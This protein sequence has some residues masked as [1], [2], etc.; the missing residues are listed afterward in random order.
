MDIN[1]LPGPYKDLA[2]YR[3]KEGWKSF[4]DDERNKNL[5]ST[6][7]KKL[8]AT[9][10]SFRWDSTPEGQSFW[11]QIWMAEKEWELPSIPINADIPKKWFSLKFKN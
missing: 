7:K 6:R 5:S 3:R 2:V 1:D 4:M 9:V 11:E 8:Y 10:D